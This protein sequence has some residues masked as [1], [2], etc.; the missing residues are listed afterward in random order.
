MRTVALLFTVNVCA[1]II[2]LPWGTTA[3]WHALCVRCKTV[4]L[5]ARAICQNDAGR[6]KIFFTGQHAKAETTSL[7]GLQEEVEDL[8]KADA[9][10]EEVLISRLDDSEALQARLEQ[11]QQQ[12]KALKSSQVS[13][14][15]LSP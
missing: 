4:S 7:Q 5:Y 3:K 13:P 11:Q 6:I 2:G 12:L 14:P 15:D 9:E 10:K 8:L 1:Q